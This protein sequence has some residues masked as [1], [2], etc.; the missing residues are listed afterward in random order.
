M[1]NILHWLCGIAEKQNPSLAVFETTALALLKEKFSY[2]PRNAA[3]ISANAHT[4]SALVWDM[5]PLVVVLVLFCDN[6]FFMLLS[7]FLSPYIL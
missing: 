1:C 6:S 4:C 7:D 2:A 3:K 5:A